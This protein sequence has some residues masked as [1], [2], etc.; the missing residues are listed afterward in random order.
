MILLPVERLRALEAA[1][2]GQTVAST[3][4]PTSTPYMSPQET[5][6]PDVELK[7]MRENKMHKTNTTQTDK[8]H[9]HVPLKNPTS[10]P[11][12]GFTGKRKSRAQ[13]F[14]KHV[15]KHKN[16]IRY[17]SGELEFD[18]I[19]VGDSDIHDLTAAFIDDKDPGEVAGWNVLMRAL[20]STDAPS[21]LYKRWRRSHKKG[22]WGALST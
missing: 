20:E 16:R 19:T 10:N 12:D 7:L 3:P 14:L 4:M 9:S 5:L 15:G 11:L 1:V 17:D 2:A 6:P 13:A 21:S 8:A 18:G 22:D